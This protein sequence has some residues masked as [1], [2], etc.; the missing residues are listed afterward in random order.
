M[1]MKTVL[2]IAGFMCFLLCGCY[3]RTTFLFLLREYRHELI[4]SDTTTYREIK[5]VCKKNNFD[6]LFIKIENDTG[7]P[8][9][10][11]IERTDAGIVFLD[12]LIIE[13][14]EVF[15]RDFNDRLFITFRAP[16]EGVGPG[17]L[18]SITFDRKDGFRIAGI[19]TSRI[20]T[21][22]INTGESKTEKNNGKGKKAGII[23]YSISEEMNRE[24]EAYISGFSSLL[25]D[26]ML[27][28][29][30]IDNVNDRVKI[31][32][33]IDD[34]K[35]EDVE[36]FFLRA[37]SLNSYCLDYLRNKG[38]FAILEEWKIASGYSDVVFLSLH[39]DIGTA[40]RE[41]FNNIEVLDSENAMWKEGNHKGHVK[42]LWGK[43]LRWPEYLSDSFV[44]RKK[45]RQVLYQG[46]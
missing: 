45:S 6:P 28:L 30:H 29:R 19:L 26:S 38:G 39:D 27:I 36:I 22:G 25:D 43:A 5:S 37:F 34:M 18:L 21:G 7:T 14:P 32:N 16:V 42:I 1:N 31:K 2:F 12:S 3:T 11:H 46:K 20:L 17:N 23:M 33:I 40:F 4:V 9:R 15:A 8:L 44:L 24:N 35:K 13:S 41:V 10:Q